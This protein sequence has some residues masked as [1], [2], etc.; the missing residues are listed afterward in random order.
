M[1]IDQGETA[2]Y[3]EAEAPVVRMLRIR[4]AISVPEKSVRAEGIVVGACWR[5]GD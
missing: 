3:C 2:L 1:E 4:A 5:G